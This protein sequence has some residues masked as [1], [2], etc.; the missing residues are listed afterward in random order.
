MSDQ[1][2]AELIARTKQLFDE[3]V[4]ESGY[5]GDLFKGVENG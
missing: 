3:S 4:A 2:L 5:T 1:A